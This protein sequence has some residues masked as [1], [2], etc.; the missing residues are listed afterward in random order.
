V[1]KF[2]NTN[3]HRVSADYDGGSVRLSAGEVREVDGAA[4]D[5]LKSVPGVETAT[6]ANAKSWEAELA[7]RSGPTGE[8]AARLEHKASIGGQRNELRQSLIAGPL[9]VVI[10]DD[11]APVG[12]PTGTVT[13]RQAVAREGDVERQAFA[14]HDALEPIEGV[15]ALDA[16]LPAAGT[17]TGDQI[18]N[19]QHENLKAA[20]AAAEAQI[21]SSGD[22]GSGDSGDSDK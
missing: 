17:F 21:S 4:A 19:A 22:S 20:E 6:A 16:R 12:P 5:A 14:D 8:G 7:A 10:G 15:D 11:Q 3:P 1:P 2:V 13:T 18:H 9:Q